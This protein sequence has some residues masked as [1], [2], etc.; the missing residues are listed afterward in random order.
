MVSADGEQ[1]RVGHQVGFGGTGSLPLKPLSSP[2][3]SQQHT[4][5]IALGQQ[6]KVQG[7]GAAASDPNALYQQQL[8]W[9]TKSS[10]TQNGDDL[11][12][13]QSAIGGGVTRASESTI[14]VNASKNGQPLVS[15]PGPPQGPGT[16][17]LQY[18]P[19]RAKQISSGSEKRLKLQ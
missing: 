11:K 3:S 14:I 5:G 17:Q 16:V 9:K 6:D 2:R 10:L 7:V 4:G 12:P 19:Q 8:Q 13:T 15:S 18:E 1:A